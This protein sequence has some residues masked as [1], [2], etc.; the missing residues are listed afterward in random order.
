M[1]SQEIMALRGRLAINTTLISTLR[2]EIE[3][4]IDQAR[5][6]LDKFIDPTELQID[7]LEVIVVR[8]KN[9]VEQIKKLISLNKQISSELGI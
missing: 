4:D 5:M 7:G 1:A 6:L 2:V 8:L 3:I 9:Q